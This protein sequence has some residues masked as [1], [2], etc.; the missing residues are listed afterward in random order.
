[1][2]TVTR[3]LLVLGAII[4]SAGPLRAQRRPITAEEIQRAGAT[5]SS[6]YDVVARLRPRWLDG[7]S[8]DAG[9]SVTRPHVYHDDHDMGEVEYLKS[10]PAERIHTI[11]W[12]SSTE[13]GIRFG[14]SE[15][16]ILVVTMKRAGPN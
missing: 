11:K 8:Q 2:A 12:L 6:A 3:T 7:A 9:A 13:A 4:L 5:V 1:M 16:P 10:I 14:A 15:G